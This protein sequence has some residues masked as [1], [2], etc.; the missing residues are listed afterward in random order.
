ME[1]SR[2]EKF[3]TKKKSNK[4]PKVVLVAVIASTIGT[5]SAFA[6][7]KTE[8]GDY[9]YNQILAFAFKTDMQNELKAEKDADLKDLSTRI[10]AIFS[11]TQRDLENEKTRLITSKK[12]EIKAHYNSEYQKITER[13]QEAVNQK[14]QEMN[15][16]AKNISDGYKAEITAEIE[17][18]VIKAANNKK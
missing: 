15:N 1:I 16:E 14:T 12:A 2:K 18:E 10:Q 4:W 13:K 5:T 8:I 9:L 3:G 7:S 6:A 17:K 11:D